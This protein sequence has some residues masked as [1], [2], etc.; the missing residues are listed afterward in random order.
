MPDQHA[1]R[2]CRELIAAASTDDAV[3]ALEYAGYWN[4][5]DV[6]RPL[7][8]NPGNL[9]T[10]AN[11]QSDPIAALAEKLTNSVDARLINACL[12]SDAA[13]E[14]S[15]GP[16]SPRA[17]VARF[18]EKLAPAGEKFGG[19]VWDWTA[20][21]RAAHA[22]K[23]TVAVSGGD[24][25]S[26][27]CVSV[28]DAGEGQHPS[29][30]PTTLCS[31]ADSNKDRIPFAQG[32]YNMGGSGALRF[33]GRHHMQLIV[34]RRNPHIAG[35]HDDGVWGFTVLRREQ[36]KPGHK[37]PVYT[38]LAPREAERTPC[39][40]EVLRFAAPHMEIFPDDSE[41][42]A[43]AAPVA[44][45]RTSEYGTLVKLYDYLP[46]LAKNGVC[47]TARFSLLRHLEVCL[48]DLALP[49]K[50]Y[51]C[52][53]PATD[54]GHLS[55]SVA[56][57]GLASR[58][59]RYEESGEGSALEPGFPDRQT[60]RIEGQDV[61]V[62]VY[63]FALGA[64]SVPKANMYR[65]GEY[66]VVFSLNNQAHARKSWQ[67]FHRKEVG[68][69]L[70]SR[71]LLVNVDCTALSP[72]ERDD[73]F[74]ASRDRIA[75]N[76]F[77]QVLLD[78]LSKSLK[79]NPK[80]KELKERR[81]R[82]MSAGG[83]DSVKA[84]E[85]V[86]R[87]LYD[88]D[89]DLLK[90]LVD[91][92]RLPMP[93]PPAPPPPPFAGKWRPTFFRHVKNPA[94]RHV[95]RRVAAG[96][97]SA[98][99]FQTDVVDDYFTRDV[100][101]GNLD[102]RLITDPPPGKDEAWGMLTASSIRL[103]DGDAT[104]S[105]KVND[106]EPG[107]VYRYEVIVN[108]R[109]MATTRFTNEF[110]LEITD[111]TPNPPKPK[112]KPNPPARYKLP[113]MN[114]VKQEGWGGMSPPFTETTAVRV[115]HGGTDRAGNDVYDWFWNE[116]N[117]AL[118]TQTRRAARAGRAGQ[119]EVIRSTFYQAMLLTALSALRTHELLQRQHDNNDGEDALPSV[120]DFVAHTTSAL[121]PVAWHIIH[122]LSQL[123]ETGHTDHVDG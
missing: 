57:Y 79:G 117:A 84:A 1:A 29:M 56:M 87:S 98:L 71:S 86:I 97:S 41:A 101:A 74:M 106:A 50:V 61:S 108:D 123:D 30:F 102:V 64:K 109:T 54:R 28:A 14:D 33:C 76:H 105:V 95:K 77:A 34:S 82:E 63:A 121:A 99:K 58:L 42:S 7:G 51:D 13:A 8:D 75:D 23:I 100:D 11:Q 94:G 65:S 12:V 6:W 26:A 17:A 2:L 3:A 93:P 81:T 83:A 45:G 92:K 78:E 9:S 119:A 25:K 53:H 37:N 70:L 107:D 85:K 32:R 112:P 52:R 67:F 118:A 72:Q 120:E 15:A 39:R 48:L 49:A 55:N 113:E 90:F 21:D 91:G 44:H 40:G 80:L 43:L 115:Y 73:L 47:G 114:A 69:S 60:L 5:P 122:D 31:L 111:S 19:D 89:Q 96:R 116:D 27:A 38:Y 103:R 46:G 110:T 104:L 66:A 18:V 24:G 22:E 59:D 88:E 20:R 68:L 36:P 35:Q 16:A 10:V 62:T 4:R